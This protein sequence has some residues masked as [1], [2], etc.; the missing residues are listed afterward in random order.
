MGL[1]CSHNAFSG[2]Y[3][4]FNRLRQFVC[5]ATGGSFP[6]HWMYGPDGE[7]LHDPDGATRYH[8]QIPSDRFQCGEGYTR[9]EWPGLFE[10]LTHSDCDGEISPTWCTKV[11]NDLEKLMP[12]FEAM[13]WES[14]GHLARDGGYVSVIRQFIAGCRDAAE[15]G[16]PLTFS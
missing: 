10:F 2:A 5:A 12:Q 8:T 4:A 14:S 9:D 13:R 11:A 16:E 6:P 1:D 3:S 15:A 7:I